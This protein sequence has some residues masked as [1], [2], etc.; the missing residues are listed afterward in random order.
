[1]SPVLLS[2]DEVSWGYQDLL[3]FTFLSMLAVLIS[4]IVMR[5]L[6]GLLH[7]E[8]KSALILIPSQLLLYAGIFAVLFALIKLQYGRDFWTSLAWTNSR[9]A[10]G[11]AFLLGLACAFAVQIIGVL[12]HTPDVDTPIKKLLSSKAAIL[13]FGILATTIGPLCEELVFRGFIQPVFI[14]SLGRAAGIVLTASLFGA[15]HLAQNAFVWQFGLLIS[16]AGVAFG[17]MRDWTGST[18]ASTWMHAGF[19]STVFLYLFQAPKLPHI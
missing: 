10:P 5:A 15:L 19:N 4:Q 17:V 1:M 8:A 12:L 11:A 3:I 16:L 14:R 13:E 18:R 9:V 6:A 2:T 7:V